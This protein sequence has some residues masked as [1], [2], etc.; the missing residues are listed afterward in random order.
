[1]TLAWTYEDALALLKEYNKE[2]FHLR[3][4]IT[5]GQVMD[6]FAKDLGYGDDAHF[7]RIAGLVHD[8]DYEAYP[9]QHCQ[10][11]PDILKEAGATEDLIHAVCSHGYGIVSDVE[12][13]HPMEKV[14][15]AVDELTGLIYANVLVR[16][17]KSTQDITLKSMKKKFKDK[18]FAAGCSRETIRKGAEI[19]GWTLDDLMAKTLQ[20]MQATE[21]DIEKLVAEATA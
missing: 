2:D 20:A 21:E 16:P 10:K 15:Y 9:D 19:L 14:L 6:W 18:S 17:S 3:H 12:P 7:W 13:I 4:G 5:V 1:M 8:I 11:A